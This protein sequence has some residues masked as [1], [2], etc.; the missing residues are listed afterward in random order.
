VTTNV[1][2]EYLEGRA[3]AAMADQSTSSTDGQVV[4]IRTGRAYRAPAARSSAPPDLERYRRSEEP[5]DFRHRM[6]VNA[7]AF[8][9]V[10]F[11]I[12]AGLWLADA[13]ATMR[14]NQDCV[15]SGKRGCSPVETMKSR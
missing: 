7:I 6:T 3:S 12:F 10:A 13:L 8:L 2:H 5:D 15:L 14:K 9:F 4:S 1:V 11:L